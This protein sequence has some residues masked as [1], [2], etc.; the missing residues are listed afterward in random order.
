MQV[1]RA[2]GERSWGTYVIPPQWGTEMLLSGIGGRA[3]SFLGPDL[4]G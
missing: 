2:P 3:L 4:M 1:S